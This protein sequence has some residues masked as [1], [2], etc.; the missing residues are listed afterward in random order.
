SLAEAAGVA[1]VVEGS[2][3]GGQK[4]AD[5]A[6]RR[7]GVSATGG[8]RFFHGNGTQ[9]RAQWLGV[10]SWLD[11]VLNTD[12]QASLATAAA[13]RTFLIYASQLKGLA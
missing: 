3:L 13:K 9:T 4:L 7:L 12:Q 2:A 6:N 8:G 1:Y 10:T 11:R 5:W